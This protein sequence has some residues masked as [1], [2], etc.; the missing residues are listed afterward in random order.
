M[1]FD[2]RYRYDEKADKHYLVVPSEYVEALRRSYVFGPAGQDLS[3]PQAINEGGH[4]TE[5]EVSV[6]VLFTG[7]PYIAVKHINWKNFVYDEDVAKRIMRGGDVELTPIPDR[8]MRGWYRCATCKL[9]VHDPDCPS[10]SKSC[11]VCETVEGEEAPLSQDWV[12]SNDHLRFAPTEVYGHREPSEPLPVSAAD[13]I[14]LSSRHQV[15]ARAAF[16]LLTGAD[17]LSFRSRTHFNERRPH[18]VGATR[19][20]LANCAE[21]HVDAARHCLNV[22]CDMLA[23]FTR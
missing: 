21:Y 14:A 1:M 17:H 3:P 16:F 8:E 23:E 12:N 5:R 18:G 19:T 10:C 9:V 7:R 15:F 6:M 22:A 13:V 4:W 11:P 20:E 2:F